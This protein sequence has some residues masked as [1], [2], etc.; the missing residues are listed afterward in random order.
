MALPDYQSD[1]AI[2]KHNLDVE[3]ARQPILFMRYGELWASAVRERD[4]AK[5]AISVVRARVEKE[6][7][8]SPADY[9]LDKIT[10]AAVKSAV[11][12][13]VDVV[14]V[15]QDFI[16]K[17]YEVNILSLAVEGFRDRRKELENLINLMR[18]L[19][20]PEP[21][22]DAEAQ[23]V[24]SDSSAD[25]HRQALKGRLPIRRQGEKGK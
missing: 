17:Q 14:S 10:E 1:L 20:W 12:M 18:M 19:Y 13:A 22:V 2:D 16:E 21:K 25:Q 4:K 3:C 23:R 8:A 15:E 11:E 24:F 9:D 7:R 5:R 6:V